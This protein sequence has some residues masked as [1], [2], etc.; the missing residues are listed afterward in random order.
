MYNNYYSD[1]NKFFYTNFKA[2][3]KLEQS[4]FIILINVL[5]D[6]SNKKRYVEL[7]KYLVQKITIWKPK[8]YFVICLE[9]IPIE[10]K[11]ELI[12]LTE[13]EL[14]LLMNNLVDKII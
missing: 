1:R 14:Y 4:L 8:P 6:S 11:R 13:P 7:G 3:K 5:D 9:D 2:L 12:Q 10:I